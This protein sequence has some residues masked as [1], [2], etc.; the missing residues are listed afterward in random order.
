[1][2]DLWI[3]VWPLKKKKSFSF[4]DFVYPI[5]LPA[6]SSNEEDMWITGWGKTETGGLF[7][8]DAIIIFLVKSFYFSDEQQDE[9]ES[10]GSQIRHIEMHRKI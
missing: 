8:P 5:C 10:I 3:F 4:A 6:E 9:N 1:M 7:T 2:I